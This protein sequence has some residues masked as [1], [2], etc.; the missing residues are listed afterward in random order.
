M[1]SRADVLFVLFLW[2]MCWPLVFSPEAQAHFGMMIPSSDIVETAKE[3]DLEL[4]VMFAHPFEGVSLPMARPAV[5]GV[6]F[7]GKKD[8]LT[9]SL[10]SMDVKLY[11]DEAPS[12]GWKTQYKIKRPGDYIFYVEPQPYWEPAEDCYII[13]YTKV[14]V[15]AFGKEDG[16]AQ[17]VGLKTEIIPLSRPFGLYSGNVFQG[18]IKVNGQPA[19]FT[20]VEVE[21]FNE[22][23]Q[24]HAKKTPF[25]TQVVT[26]DANGIFT[27]AMP[28]EGW[29]GFA[30]L[31]ED[32]KTLKYGD[33]DKSVEI[34]AVL[35]IK[36]YNME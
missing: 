35:W 33:E 36:T 26:S 34:G 2:G 3:G 4:K 9:D 10:K 30:A 24:Y 15:N 1:K 12:P 23:G 21:Y 11:A 22:R 16:W 8:D 31:S 20:D 5:F 19:P 25:V 6:F 18:I 14:I 13:H 17:E 7:N 27:Y 32:E 28:Q 29:W